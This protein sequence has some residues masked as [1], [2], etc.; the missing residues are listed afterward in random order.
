MRKLYIAAA[1]YLGFGL[2]IGVFY[3][4]WTRVFDAVDRSQLNTLHTHTLILGTFFF[5]IVLALEK[6]FQ[7]S[8]KQEASF[9]QWFIVHNVGLAWTLLAM[10]ANGIVHTMGNGDSWGAAQSGIAGL[11]HII[12]TVG[13]V[14]FFVLLNKAIKR[15]EKA[16]AADA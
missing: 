6:L 2:T 14:W 4:E 5:L 15:S 13:F 7:I 16:A 9:K 12:L 3:R 10:L 8:E 11:G 1:T